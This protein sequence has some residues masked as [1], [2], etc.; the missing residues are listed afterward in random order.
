M[1]EEL[2]PTIRVV[3]LPKDTNAYG[4]V[5][6]GVIMS[7][8]DIAG[9]I[10]AR[11]HTAHRVVTV[12]IDKIEF[13]APVF[14]GDVV[15]FYTQLQSVGRTSVTVS[16]DVEADRTD[17]SGRVRVTQARAVYVALNDEGRPTPVRE[18]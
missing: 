7:H 5:F 18:V 11:K 2:S 12:A 1:T 14:V 6:G 3:L 13:V 16:I 15:S 4:V 8:L 9:A 17:G 10:E